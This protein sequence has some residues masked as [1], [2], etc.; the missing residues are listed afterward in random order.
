MHDVSSRGDWGQEREGVRDLCFLLGL[1]INPKRLSKSIK[2]F[3][4][5]QKCTEGKWII[6]MDF[7]RANTVVSPTEE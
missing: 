3:L 6:L 7:H 4:N 5:I 2:I 1:F